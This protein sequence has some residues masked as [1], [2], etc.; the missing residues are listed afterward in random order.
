MHF[1]L[2]TFILCSSVVYYLTIAQPVFGQDTLAAR[3]WWTL[4][5]NAMKR[6][7]F[8]SSATYFQFAARNYLSI[9][10]RL[11]RQD[12]PP[13]Y[14]RYLHS[15]LRM[16]GAQIL[17]GKVEKPESLYLSWIDEARQLLGDSSAVLVWGLFHFGNS[18]FER[19]K[20]ADAE[21][22]WI[23]A[24]SISKSTSGNYSFI[25]ALLNQRLASLYSV[26]NS[27]HKPD[28]DKALSTFHRAL[29]IYKQLDGSRARMGEANIYNSIGSIHHMLKSLPEALEAHINALNIFESIGTLGSE[30]IAFTCSYISLIYEE[31]GDRQ[32]A[33]EYAKRGQL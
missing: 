22:I 31:M 18:E 21:K 8:D 11:S 32:K 26:S 2:K 10:Q 30:E 19:D 28:Y 20:Y 3:R 27:L 16:I 15:S 9:A 23:Q 4:G 29:E 14:Q 25:G 13:I 6:D 12:A 33:D 5:V 17:T 7:Q 24:L 1:S